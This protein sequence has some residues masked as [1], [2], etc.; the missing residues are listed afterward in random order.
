MFPTISIVIPTYNRAPVLKETLAA[1]LRQDH[2]PQFEIIVADDGS[3]DETRQVVADLAAQ[4]SQTLNRIYQEN[5]GAAAARNLGLQ[6]A[7]G[8][9]L[10]FMDDDTIALPTLVAEHFRS[11]SRYTDNAVAVL[12]QEVLAPAVRA[13]P[14]NRS[15]VIPR[16]HALEDGQEVDWTHFLTGNIS[17]KRSFL[18]DHELYFDESLSRFQDTE[19]GYRCWKNG[20]RIIYNAKAAAYHLHDL[21]FAAWIRMNYDY[22][23]ALAVLHH[24]Y[25]ELKTQLGEYM[26]FSW[27]NSPGRVVYDLLRPVFLNRFTAGVLIRLGQRLE[28]SRRNIPAFVSD[29]AGNYYERSAYQKRMRAESRTPL[30]VEDPA[31]VRGEALGKQ[32]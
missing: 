30:V 17:L 32:P 2:A 12:G 18:T 6:R 24:E 14:V 23:N 3:T 11:H 15:H 22:G 19:M 28:A 4:A 1:L 13:T 7:R 5:R 29:R 26:V 27:R 20:L 25:P 21:N 31:A 8:Q 9:I 16:W 10:L